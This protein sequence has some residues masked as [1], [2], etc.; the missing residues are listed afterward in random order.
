MIKKEWGTWEELGKVP[1]TIGPMCG[2]VSCNSYDGISPTFESP[3][4]QQSVERKKFKESP[5]RKYKRSY[6]G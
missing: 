2:Q 5:K 6:K 3:N 1:K 4:L